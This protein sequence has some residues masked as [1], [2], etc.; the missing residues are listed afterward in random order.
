MANLPEEKPDSE[1]LE[2]QAKKPTRAHQSW[3]GPPA[4]LPGRSRWAKGKA[5]P[6]SGRGH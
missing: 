6:A 5:C 3:V 2:E 4:R 1:P